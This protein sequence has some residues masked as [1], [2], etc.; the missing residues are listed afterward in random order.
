MATGTGAC[1]SASGNGAF[2]GAV[3]ARITISAIS[4]FRQ[5]LLNA[6]IPE[7]E[8]RVLVTAD[9]LTYWLRSDLEQ[10]AVS[11]EA[12][13]SGDAFLAHQVIAEPFDFVAV[14][15]NDA[16]LLGIV[17]RLELSA[18]IAKTELER[19]ISQVLRQATTV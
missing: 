8:L 10:R 4:S 3:A 6:G 19:H 12:E 9:Q 18:R 5:Q 16:K 11:I 17:D 2:G 1:W 7:K 13:T 14:V 15:Q